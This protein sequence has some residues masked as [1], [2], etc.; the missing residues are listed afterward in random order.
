MDRDDAF[1]RYDEPLTPRELEMVRVMAESYDAIVLDPAG[2]STDPAG[3]PWLRRPTSRMGSRHFM[4]PNFFRRMP[5]SAAAPMTAARMAHNLSRSRRL[6]VSNSASV[7]CF[8]SASS[9]WR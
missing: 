1:S 5:T 2:V 3:D 4:K 8:A 6:H 9:G 7:S